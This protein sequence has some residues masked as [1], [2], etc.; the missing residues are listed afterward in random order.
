MI[1]QSH[2]KTKNYN[3]LKDKSFE[4]KFLFSFCWFMLRKQVLIQ[5][6]HSK[7]IFLQ[8]IVTGYLSYIRV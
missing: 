7:I 6:Y 3:I 2:D 8:Y 1:I 5:F 4:I